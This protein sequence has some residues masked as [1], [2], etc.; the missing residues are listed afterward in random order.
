MSKRIK[1][2]VS[3]ERWKFL[4]TITVP[5]PRMFH[6]SAAVAMIPHP[7]E[8]SD[9]ATGRAT[10]NREPLQSRVGGIR[11]LGRGLQGRGS[12]EEPP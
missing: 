8:R 12:G 2:G 7:R 6:Q 9:G 4:K 5:E 11:H 1:N 10:H 3:K